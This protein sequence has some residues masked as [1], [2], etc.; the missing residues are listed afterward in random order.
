MDKPRRHPGSHKTSCSANHTRKQ[1][2]QRLR[3][4]QCPS[5]SRQLK[6]QVQ[7]SALDMLPCVCSQQELTLRSDIVACRA[8]QDGVLRAPNKHCSQVSAPYTAPE[9]PYT[10]SET[11]VKEDCKCLMAHTHTHTCT[12]KHTGMTCEPTGLVGL[13]E[14]SEC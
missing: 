4:P 13:T 6:V 7:A 12:S 3:Q 5:E 10:L 14:R 1:T 8:A 9:R 2:A 11:D